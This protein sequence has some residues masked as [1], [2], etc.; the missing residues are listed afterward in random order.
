[1]G[2]VKAE[3]APPS[4]AGAMTRRRAAEAHAATTTMTRRRSAQLG[5]P[6]VKAAAV[7]AKAGP[8]TTATS[9][10]PA[11]AA[12][13]RAGPAKRGKS[14]A[15]PP[16]AAAAAAPSPARRT[17]PK[18][19][20]S[21]TA[22][23][24]PAATAASPPKRSKRTAAAAAAAPATAATTPA[25]A[26]RGTRKQR[27]LKGTRAPPTAGGPLGSVDPRSNVKGAICVDEDGVVYDVTLNLRD[28]ATNSDKYYILQLIGA[29]DGRFV[30]FSHWGRTGTAGQCL[31]VEFAPDGEDGEEA[32]LAAALEAFGEKFTD[33]S[34]LAFDATTVAG[35]VPPVPGKYRVVIM[36]HAARAE[37]AAA[38]DVPRWQYWV[39][40]GVDGKAVGWYDYDAGGTV[41]TEGLFVEWG[42]NGWLSE[43]VVVSGMWT[44]LVN[45]ADMSQ[46]NLE[47]YAHTRRRIRR[48]PPGEVPDSMPPV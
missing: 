24:A 2:G 17:A 6:P 29:D 38:M 19:G 32:G 30:V 15:E 34:G 1:M 18:R 33:K 21:R 44:Y 14:K 4:P 23:A 36:D 46:T 8:P 9:P 20:A 40:D 27:G 31:S 3:P 47:H 5:S 41:T 22:A 37:A 11:P 12:A 42:L 43:R 7:K 13:R 28:S 10:A 26:K 48:V 25:A 35:A 45:L 39:A 16:V